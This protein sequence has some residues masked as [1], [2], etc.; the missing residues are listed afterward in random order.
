MICKTNKMIR[1]LIIVF[2]CL[3]VKVNAQYKISANGGWTISKLQ[4]QMAPSLKP[5]VIYNELYAFPVH[6]A[7][8]LSFEYEYDWK[9]WHFSTGLSFMSLGTG[10]FM[11]DDTPWTGDYISIPLAIG[12]N[13][14]LPKGFGLTLETGIEAGLDLEISYVTFNAHKKRIKGNVNL[15]L[16][17]EGNWKR[18]R[19]GVRA[20]GGVTEF[21]IIGQNRD[22]VLRHSAIT[23]YIGYTFWD[24]K[25]AKERRAKQ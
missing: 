24:S 17:I 23:T 15:I 5:G 10:E 16:G 2:L 19:L 13:W 12:L 21:E 1:I 22:L 6:H 8:Y 25:K 18:F 11:F 9:S 14:D 7:P 20:Q 4:K 3:C